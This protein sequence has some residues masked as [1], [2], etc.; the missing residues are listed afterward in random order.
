MYASYVELG[1]VGAEIGGVCSGS[2][3]PFGCMVPIDW[4]FCLGPAV[5][6]V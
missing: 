4:V 5:S 6:Y 3:K 1:V 2:S